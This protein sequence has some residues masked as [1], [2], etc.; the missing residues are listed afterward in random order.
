M[1]WLDFQQSKSVFHFYDK[2]NVVWESISARFATVHRSHC[3]SKQ[4]TIRWTF[5]SFTLPAKQILLV[6]IFKLNLYY[7]NKPNISNRSERFSCIIRLGNI[8]QEIL[9][10]TLYL[11]IIDL[12]K[13]DK[14]F[15][16]THI[17]YRFICI[18]VILCTVI[19][20]NADLIS[21]N[22]TI[23]LIFDMRTSH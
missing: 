9:Q 7:I 10:K 16:Y 20:D 21:N 13:F 19:K 14:K 2:D 12:Y 11:D 18:V 1:P 22:N 4:L 23:V 8:Y 6:Y 15:E 5:W 17:H 3:W